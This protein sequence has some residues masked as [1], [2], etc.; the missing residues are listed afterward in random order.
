MEPGGHPKKDVQT[1]QSPTPALQQAP[2]HGLG[3]QVDPTDSKVPMHSEW[4]EML[5]A[6]VPPQHAP[7]QGLEPQVR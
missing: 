7:T 5:H 2:A 3:V 4:I 6:P 1:A